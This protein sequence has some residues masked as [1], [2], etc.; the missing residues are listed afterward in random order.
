ME[1]D[2]YKREQG[3]GS[4]SSRRIF[5]M[6]PHRGRRN[7]R[8][9]QIAMAAMDIA[10]LQ[11]FVANWTYRLGLHGKLRVT[12]HDVDLATEG[13]LPAP[14]V[15]A[16]ASDLHAGPT[17]HPEIFSDLFNEVIERRPDALLLGG[18]FVSSKAEHVD[19]LS[20]GLSRCNPPL[21]K[22]AVLGNHDLWTDEQLITRK[23]NAAGVEVL[24][25]RNVS[26]AFPFDGVSICGID[27]PWTGSADTAKAFKD[28]KPVRIFLMHS[29]DGLLLL[30][31]EKYAL[32]LAGHT[33]GG[34]IALRDGTPIIGAGGPLSRSHA[35]GRFEVFG[36]GPLIVSRGIG[37]SNVPV[38]IN[39]DPELIICTLRSR[40][41]L[42]R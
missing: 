42:H 26:L 25:N 5:S 17:T 30:G 18:D 37:C 8:I 39:S 36:N 9:R 15:L 29:P 6:T 2:W 35:R 3:G 19:A 33:H 11:G 1:D 41:V 20:L 23:L 24:V 38:R 22:F 34:Q 31:G 40:P 16:F 32:G 4:F 27:D 28:A 10:L 7:P 14:L 12:T 13:L 21:G